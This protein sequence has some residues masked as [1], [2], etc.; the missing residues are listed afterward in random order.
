MK[1]HRTIQRRRTSQSQEF[2]VSVRGAATSS[3]DS[4]L[5]STTSLRTQQLFSRAVRTTA[6]SST[7]TG[8]GSYEEG[9][10]QRRYSVLSPFCHYAIIH[11]LILLYPYV[12]VCGF[13]CHLHPFL[14]PYFNFPSSYLHPFS[15]PCKGLFLV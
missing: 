14:Y 6:G 4:W 11:L 15:S 9:A 12:G 1:T 2:R 3:T 5:H 8:W 10:R 13:Y 7:V